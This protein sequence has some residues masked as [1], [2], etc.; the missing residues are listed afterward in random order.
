MKNLMKVVIIL[1][2][3]LLNGCA[4]VADGARQ[5]VL[6][7]TN[8]RMDNDTE[9]RLTNEEGYWT[10]PANEMISIRRDGNEMGITCENSKQSGTRTV[11]PTFSVSFLFLDIFS[12]MCIG[13][14]PDAATNAFYEYPS[15]IKVKMKDKL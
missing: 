6:V 3:I 4:T 12:N 14:I 8:N 13:C 9:C 1:V 10:T 7:A 5:T 2:P 11:L 15:V